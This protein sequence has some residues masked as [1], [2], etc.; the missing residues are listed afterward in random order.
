MRRPARLDWALVGGG[1]VGV[2]VAELAVTDDL[3]GPL[4]LNVARRRGHRGAPGVVAHLSAAGHGLP[5][6]GRAAGASG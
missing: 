4:A 2:R 5:A 3:R 6:R 1:L